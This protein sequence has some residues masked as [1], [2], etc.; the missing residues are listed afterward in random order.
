MSFILRE[1]NFEES[2][3]CKSA[4]FAILE[5][6]NFIDLVNF[7]LQ[8]VQKCIKIKTQS[9]Q[10]WLQWQSLDLKNY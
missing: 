6:L 7:S 9:L 2:R 10:L 3:S 1:I 8:K 4:Y 5:P